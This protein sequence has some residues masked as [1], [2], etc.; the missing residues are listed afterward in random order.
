MQIAYEYIGDFLEFG[1]D[2]HL[3][4]ARLEVLEPSMQMLWQAEELYLKKFN[5]EV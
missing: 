5:H 2:E 4:S 3:R 1:E